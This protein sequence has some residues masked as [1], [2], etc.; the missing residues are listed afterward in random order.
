MVKRIKNNKM[1]KEGGFDEWGKVY[2]FKE[3]K[4]DEGIN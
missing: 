1:K 4:N 3:L 2:M